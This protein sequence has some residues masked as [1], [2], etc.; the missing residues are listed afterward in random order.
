MLLREMVFEVFALLKEQL[1]T[2]T[3]TLEFEMDIFLKKFLLRSIV[4]NIVKFQVYVIIY[5]CSV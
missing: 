4:Y 3:L 5:Q 2:C 1:G